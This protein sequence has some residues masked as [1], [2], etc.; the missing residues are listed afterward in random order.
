MT[1]AQKY[2]RKSPQRKALLITGAL[3]FLLYFGLG[4][5]FLFIKN[6]PFNMPRGAKT[7]FGILLIAYSLFRLFRLWQD[8]NKEEE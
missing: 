7:G 4:I 8:I 1:F 2:G 5:M 3:F 6:L